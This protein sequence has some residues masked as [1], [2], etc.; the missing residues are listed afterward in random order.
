MK[1]SGMKTMQDLKGEIKL[2]TASERTWAIWVRVFHAHSKGELIS[3]D[4]DK[5]YNEDLKVKVPPLLREFFRPLQGL[6]D[7]ALQGGSTPSQ[8]DSEKDSAIPQDILEASKVY[9]AFDVPY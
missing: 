7:S 6:L 3:L 4:T 5:K 2:I 8:G 9:E 1:Q